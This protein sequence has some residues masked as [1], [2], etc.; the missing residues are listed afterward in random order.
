MDFD[1]HVQSWSKH[2]NQDVEHFHFSKKF[3]TIPSL[4]LIPP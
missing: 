3:P 4:P 2:H 1:K